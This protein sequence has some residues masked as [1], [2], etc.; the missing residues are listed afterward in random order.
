MFQLPVRLPLGILTLPHSIGPRKTPKHLDRLDPLYSY[1]PYREP[2]LEPTDVQQR[3]C[4][5]MERRAHTVR[6]WSSMFNVRF[7]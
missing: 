2:V 3:T 4:T 6:Q 1:L 5:L 7:L